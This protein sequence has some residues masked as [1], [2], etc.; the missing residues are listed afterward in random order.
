LWRRFRRCHS[1]PSAP[2]TIGS[3]TLAKTSTK[4]SAPGIGTI[5]SASESAGGFFGRYGISQIADANFSLNQV[6]AC[7]F[8][9]RTGDLASIATGT[10]AQALD[11]GN[12]LTLNGQNNRPML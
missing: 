7:Y 5:D 8:Y 6:G 4:I 9:R 3:L 12:Q 1:R 2:I 11:A 10:P